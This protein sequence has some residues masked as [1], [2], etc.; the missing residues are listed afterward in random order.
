[1]VSS[2]DYTQLA[3]ALLHNLWT[4]GVVYC[5][6]RVVYALLGEE[7]PH[8]RY[9]IGVAALVVAVI[10]L[11]FT[12]F[13]LVHEP[14]PSPTPMETWPVAETESVATPA[15]SAPRAAMEIPVVRYTNA[16]G[17]FWSSLD[18]YR[19]ACAGWMLGAALMLVRLL[20]NIIATNRFH[21]RCQVIEDGRVR[22]IFD[23]VAAELGIGFRVLLLQAA[24][25]AQPAALGLIRPAVV[26]PV[27]MLTGLDEQQLRAVLLHELL[28]IRRYDYLFNLLQSLIEAVLFF[29]P[30]VW[31]LGRLVRAERESAC[32]VIAARH[33]GDSRQYARALL[34]AASL[35]LPPTSPLAAGLGADDSNGFANRLRRLLRPNAGARIRLPWNGLLGLALLAGVLIAGTLL[36]TQRGAIL[37]AQ[38]LTPEERVAAIAE[39]DEEARSYNDGPLT[40]KGII[41]D[42]HGD[43][44]LGKV[45]FSVI[46]P[47]MFGSYGN[48]N[49]DGRFALKDLDFGLAT[50]CVV[51]DGYPPA[52]V[53][54]FRASD[55]NVIDDIE[56]VLRPGITNV[57]RIVDEEGNPLPNVEIKGGHKIDSNSFSHTIRETT[58][59]SGTLTIQGHPE[60]PVHLKQRTDGFQ[61]SRRDFAVAP[62]KSHTWRLETATPVRGHVI[63]ESTGDPVADAEV[64]LMSHYVEAPGRSWH[65]GYGDPLTGKIEATTDDSGIFELT[66]LIDEASYHISIHKPGY[67]T[68]VV[69]DVS[70][71]N[72]EISIQL[73][74]PLHLAGTVDPSFERGYAKMYL[75]TSI[76]SGAHHSS[77]F[78]LET[79][80]VD[81]AFRF[82][83]LFPGE[84]QLRAG[85]SM[86]SMTI[87]LDESRNDVVFG[88]PPPMIL[89]DVTLVPP[90]GNPLPNGDIT[91]HP[92]FKNESKGY[93]EVRGTRRFAVTNGRAT[94]EVPS[95]AISYSVDTSLSQFWPL[96]PETPIGLPG[97]RIENAKFDMTG[98]STARA[99]TILIKP[100]GAATVR[101]QSSNREAVGAP[102]VGIVNKP[103]KAFEFIHPHELEK[104][105][106]KTDGGATYTALPLDETY[107][108]YARVA[109]GVVLS[110]EVRLSARNPIAEVVLELREPESLEVRVLNPDGSP[111]ADVSVS[112]NCRVYHQ[113]IGNHNDMTDSDGRVTLR[114]IQPDSDI[115][116]ALQASDASGQYASEDVSSFRDPVTLQLKPADNWQQD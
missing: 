64:R 63:D 38:L 32:D 36:V 23:G 39:L 31:M 101:V 3:M 96:E 16:P 81:G 104:S 70:V 108:F 92:A 105:I 88:E 110:P 67:A 50:L 71:S 28:H 75:N 115:E 90:E 42:E 109:G 66:T 84:W 111:A 85:N 18:G 29:N 62:G 17:L 87:Q 1:M 74:P 106:R 76:R 14:A 113:H 80:V 13:F 82:D 95:N 11:P 33:L 93:T 24:E 2:V 27:S 86:S 4:V 77:S 26:L 49:R 54:P 79:D 41:L 51:A 73:K 68:N 83:H 98:G 10:A 21:R 65:Q 40:L 57:I 8:A 34:E 5:G 69:K 97:Y 15:T 19:I 94:I 103:A 12:Y 55:G 107:R 47:Q 46:S 43:P 44:F 114:N 53:G 72:P 116:Y 91:V 22:R 102:R 20:R 56:I 52:V 9:V 59:A 78:S 6:V 112:L 58:D 99:V 100:A 48:R 37:T 60:Y 30:F 61:E 7:R 45:Q 25:V 89:V 35:A